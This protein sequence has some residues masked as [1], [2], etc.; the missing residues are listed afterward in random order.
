MIEAAKQKAFDELHQNGLAARM[1]DRRCEQRLRERVLSEFQSQKSLIETALTLTVCVDSPC[2]DELN[3]LQEF[4]AAGDLDGLVARYPLHKSRV[5]DAI[6]EALACPNR[7]H[8][9]KIVLSR[10]RADAELAQ[11]LKEHIALLSIELEA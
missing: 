6:A 3:R 2:P 8:Y 9:E 7:S 10:V 4:I 5:C 1:A 11:K